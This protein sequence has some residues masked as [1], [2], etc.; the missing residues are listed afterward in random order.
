M[1]QPVTM[2]KHFFLILL[3]S[4]S[5]AGTGFS[6]GTDG[7]VPED[8]PAPADSVKPVAQFLKKGL[9]SGHV[10]SY[11]LATDNKPGLTDFHALG[12]GAGISYH[13]PRL[14]KHVELGISGFFTFNVLSS[15]LAARDPKTNQPSRYEVGLFD[16]AD[17]NNR[18]DL[19]RL[20][21]LYARVYI[22]HQ[23]KLTVG[24]QIPHSPFINPQD[25]RMRPTL[26][27]A[28]VL[29]WNEWKNTRFQLEYIFGISPRS[30]VRWFTVG[31][32]FGQY[33]A[34]VDLNGK[35][36]QYAG[37]IR[38][39]G[40]FQAGLTQK[41]GP[42]SLQLWNTYVPDVLNLMYGNVEWRSS[43]T[44]PA[45]WMAGVM[46]G[47]E[48]A[49][50]TG[51][52][53]VLAQT[54]IT[55][56]ATAGFISGRLEYQSPHWVFNLNATRITAAGRLLMPREWGREPFYTFMLRERNEGTGNTTAFTGSVRYSPLKN[57]KLDL[58]TGYYHLPDVSNYA[59]NKYGLPAYTQVN[60]GTTYQF[61]GLW[62]GLDIQ[63]LLVR[64]DPV[65]WQ[66][67]STLVN[68]DRFIINKVSM[69]QLNAIANFH[70]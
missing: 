3:L 13:T 68:P 6:S 43:R 65:R 28:A 16:L 10:R 40:I 53:E 52:N 51:G 1:I 36:S 15:D 24:R 8:Q 48:Q 32:S 62:K 69:T 11:F 60:L 27:E 34:G 56:G 67:G 31:E 49:V 50:N 29:E 70:F 7:I 44:S 14:F 41:A 19:D 21:E 18:R 35:P 58:G 46:G 39:S 37:H 23:S 42:L 57:L 38:T 20:E 47:Y 2:L 5:A 59:L 45:Y 17:P 55:P 12:I 25:G 66:P 30:T 22:G 61:S 64:K 26:T 63:L 54:Y 9:F 4:C 33:P